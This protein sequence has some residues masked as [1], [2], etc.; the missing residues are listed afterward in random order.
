MQYTTR[1]S[2]NSV[3]DLVTCPYKESTWGGGAAGNS[4]SVT[5]APHQC[6]LIGA[7]ASMIATISATCPRII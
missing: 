1:P 3:T 4:V 2:G 5:D 7:G 6:A